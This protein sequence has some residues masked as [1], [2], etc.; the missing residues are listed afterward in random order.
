MYKTNWQE[1]YNRHAQNEMTAEEAF[2]MMEWEH[3]L[4]EDMRINAD[5]RRKHRKPFTMTLER[6]QGIVDYWNERG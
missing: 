2:D 5:R 6:A 3:N 1:K 4:L